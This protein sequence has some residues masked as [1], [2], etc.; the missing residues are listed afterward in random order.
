M[1]AH[2]LLDQLAFRVFKHLVR[3]VHLHD[4][5]F[6]HKNNGVRKLQSLL[7]VMCDK[8][9]GLFELLMESYD[10]ILQGIARHG[11]QGSE[12]LIH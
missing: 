3:G 7:H 6:I 12:G 2:E 8:H 9:K 11:V 1:F 10:F 5:A 4:L